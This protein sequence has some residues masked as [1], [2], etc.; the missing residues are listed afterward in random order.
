[1]SD[2]PYDQGALLAPWE[3]QP[4]PHVVLDGVWDDD[5]LR[6]CRKEFPAADDSRWITY[7]D[8][9]ERGKKAGASNMWGQMTH[10]WFR[11]VRDPRFA[12]LLS[13][14]TGIETLIPDDV[15]GGMHETGEGGRLEMHIDF[16]VHPSNPRLERRINLLVFLNE[17]WQYEWGGIIELGKRDNPHRIEVLPEFNRTVLFECSDTSF[18]GHPTP[19]VGDHLRRS[20]ACYFYAPIREGVREKAHSTVWDRG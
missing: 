15:G 20:L 11:H 9:E 5:F 1:M 6:A 2:Q 19:I 3:S 12:A 13:N 14:V 8:P 16:N 18:H 7:N 17:D 10:R 4:F